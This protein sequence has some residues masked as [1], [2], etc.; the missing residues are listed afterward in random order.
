MHV[1]AVLFFV[2]IGSNFLSSGEIVIFSLS[3]FTAQRRLTFFVVCVVFVV[4]V[5]CIMFVVC[6]VIR[7]RNSNSQEEEYN[8]E[9]CGAKRLAT[10]GPH[11]YSAD[12]AAQRS[13]AS[14]YA[15]WG[16][17]RV[18]SRAKRLG[19]GSAGLRS[20]ISH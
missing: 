8:G 16:D 10:G 20:Q 1:A 4:F 18:A 7:A 5:V 13:A 11:D 17:G 15:L 3:I 19:S 6:I 12:D 14:L 9:K 2:S